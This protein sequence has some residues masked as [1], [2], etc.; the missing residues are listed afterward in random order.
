M[1]TATARSSEHARGANQPL[2]CLHDSIEELRVAL[3]RDEVA[4]LTQAEGAAAAEQAQKE[5]TATNGVGPGR[6]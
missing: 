3:E 6:Q 2:E 5:L 1:A 4:P